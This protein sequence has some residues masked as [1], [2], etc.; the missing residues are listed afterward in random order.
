MDGATP[1]RSP[2]EQEGN[3]MKASKN[4]FS[5]IALMGAVAATTVAIGGC[6]TSAST[7]AP[8]INVPPLELTLRVCDSGTPNCAGEANFSLGSLRDLQVNADWK[9]MPGGTHT[10]K[11]ADR[12]STR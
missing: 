12:K 5:L 3:P 7:P 2:F 4:S 10:Q 9:N 8:V 1:L 11:I 6:A